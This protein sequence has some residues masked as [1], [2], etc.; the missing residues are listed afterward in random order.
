MP[1]LT[2]S[3]LD[4]VFRGRRI[5]ITGHTG[6]KGAWLAASLKR[7][8]A[9]LFGYALA[10]EEKSLYRALE[11]ETLFEKTVHRDICDKTTLH[12]CFCAWKPDGVIHLAAQAL[13]LDSLEHPVFTFETNIL[14][15]V[16]VLEAAAMTASV[17]A[18]VIVTS[19]KC[20]Q[21]IDSARA[22]DE[23]DALGGR[24]P[25]S[26]SKAAAEL[27]TQSYRFSGKLPFHTATCRAG[28]VIGGGDWCANRL[29]PDCARA[30]SSG[31]RAL[32]RN[33]SHVRPWQHVQEPVSGYIL[34]LGAMLAGKDGIDQAWNF[35][36]SNDSCVSVREVAEKFCR[37]WG[38]GAEL[39]FSQGSPQYAEQKETLTLVLSSAKAQQ[40]LGWHS[41][42]SIDEAILRTAEI[43][44]A[45]GTRELREIFQNQLTA[46][47][48]SA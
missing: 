5:L 23:T 41:Q 24:D 21:P 35:G 36:P 2:A 22:L 6:F 31:R 32:I 14:G 45:W 16:R 39:E 15:T 19:D 47:E 20:Y 1:I 28:N 4:D 33:A 9:V 25:Y 42:W 12:Q 27:V 10:P 3:E 48:K 11:I 46:Y 18:A 30:F 17:K 38:P 34:T 8:G 37:A 13:V 7:R 29:I 43:Y 44:K 26:A 40:T